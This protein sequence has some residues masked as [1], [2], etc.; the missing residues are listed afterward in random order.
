M[1]VFNG[2]P[3]VVGGGASEKAGLS[4]APPVTPVMF[5]D[6]EPI[7]TIGIQVSIGTTWWLI[8]RIVSGY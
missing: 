6:I 8:P 1:A 5:V 7:N 3:E 2:D 4:G